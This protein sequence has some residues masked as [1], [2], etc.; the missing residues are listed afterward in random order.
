MALKKLMR[1]A[2]EHMTAI[3][4]LCLH[5]CGTSQMA[6]SCRKRSVCLLHYSHSTHATSPKPASGSGATSASQHA[7]SSDSEA[8]SDSAAVRSSPHGEQDSSA[9]R[10]TACVHFH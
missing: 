5:P 6:D 2:A 8:S 7:G 9:R 1:Y 3:M 4:L 10:G